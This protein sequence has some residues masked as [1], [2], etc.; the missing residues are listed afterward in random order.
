MNRDLD[1]Y[2]AIVDRMPLRWPDGMALAYYALPGSPPVGRRVRGHSPGN[3]GSAQQ[4][5]GDAVGRVMALPAL[6]TTT[7][8]MADPD[9]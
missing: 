5:R 6:D 3:A 4:G 7:A 8:A 9:L 2:S 1:S